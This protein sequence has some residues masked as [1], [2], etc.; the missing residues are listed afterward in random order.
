MPLIRMIKLDMHLFFQACER[1]LQIFVM[2][3]CFLLLIQYLS[4]AQA[5]SLISGQIVDESSGVAVD[6]SNVSLLNFSDSSL[7]RGT[8]TDFDGRFELS[9]SPG[10]YLMRVSFLGYETYFK[11]I[12]LQEEHLDL[13]T[14][15]I[16]ESAAMLQ[17]VSVEAAALMFRTEIDKRVYDV[18]NTIA[19]EGGSAIQLLETL[20]SI[21]VDDEGQINLRGSSNLLIYINGRPTNLTSDDTESILEQYPANAIKSVE[22]ITNPSARFDAEGVGGIINLILNESELNGLNGQ[23][24]AGVGTGNKFN[25]GTTLN[26][27]S[28][29]WNFTLGYNFQYRER[30]EYSESLRESF[31]GNISPVLDQQYDTENWDR[32]H[33][34]RPGIEYQFNE[35]SSINLF[36]S[37]NLRS[38]DRER[39][40]QIR[41]RDVNHRQDSAYIRLLEEDQSRINLEGGLSFQT[42]FG[43]EGYDFRAMFTHSWSDQDRIEYFDQEFRDEDDL[44]VASKRELQTYERPLESRLSLFQLDFSMPLNEFQF[45]IGWKTTFSSEFRE[46]IFND[47]DFSENS[48]KQNALLTD[49]FDFDENIHAAYLILGGNTGRWGYQAGLRAEYTN[50]ESYQPRIDSTHTNNYF[51]LFPSAFL[52]Y[53]LAENTIIQASYSRRISRPSMGRLMPFLNAQDLLN[54]RLGNPYLEPQ[55]TDNY[56]LSFDKMW[57][58][59]FFTASLFH[60]NAKNTFT[61]VYQLFED[62]SSVVTWQNADNRQS[63][64]LEIVNQ[65]FVNRN[66]DLSLTTSIYHNRISGE[67][68]SGRYSNSRM[69]WTVNL[70]GNT[71]ISNWFSFQLIANYRG[72]IVLPQGSIDPRYSLNIGF[73]REVLNRNG[74]ISLSVSDVLKTRNFTLNTESPDFN[75]R[76]YFERESRVLNLSFTY[77]FRGYQDRSDRRQQQINGGEDAVF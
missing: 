64:G 14:I 3:A 58:E 41:S 18:S 50:T 23:V 66:T 20:P 63:T 12:N 6:F 13:R 38:R 10:E 74:T 76:R 48:F 56:E 33:L 39:V 55:Y 2:A 21:Q 44:P 29:G 42:N 4:F 57:E 75:Q 32:T 70:M 22:V 40:Y 46:Q 31:R 19:A 49:Q 60:R 26:Y 62:R 35:H 15:E 54:M 67:D 11:K 59:F 28:N 73:R 34:L 51:D 45:E 24:T 77:R 43:R 37:M 65:W 17:E 47:F 9:A 71:R 27:R 52:S 30:W 8:T 61:R 36:S 53:E 68:E 5:Q 1:T 7:V 69:S 16:R 25:V 72:P